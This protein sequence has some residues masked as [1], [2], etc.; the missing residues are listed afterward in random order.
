MKKTKMDNNTSQKCGCKVMLLYNKKLQLCGH[1][2]DYGSIILCEK[3]LTIH[4]N[5]FPETEILLE[6]G[7]SIK[8]Y[9]KPGEIK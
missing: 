9:W 3:C 2:T 6:D 5:S 4:M 1:V 8:D 7:C